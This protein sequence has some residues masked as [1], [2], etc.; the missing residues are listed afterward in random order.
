M[1]VGGYYPYSWFEKWSSFEGG[2]DKDEEYESIKKIISDKFINQ[3]A[4]LYPKIKVKGSDIFVPPLLTLFH[5]IGR[6]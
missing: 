6:D 5:I 4:K 3:A 1:F 2:K